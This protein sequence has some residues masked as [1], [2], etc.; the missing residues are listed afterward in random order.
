LRDLLELLVEGG[1]G[2][3]IAGAVLGYDAGGVRL[4]RREKDSKPEDAKASH[5]DRP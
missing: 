1:G 2:I 5:A 3:S 4:R